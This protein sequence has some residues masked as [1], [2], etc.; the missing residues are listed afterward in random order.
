MDFRENLATKIGLDES[1]LPFVGEMLEV[2]EEESVWQGAIER[3]LKGFALSLLIEDKHY[4]ALS[5]FLNSTH[6][7]R[8]VV[9]YRTSDVHDS[10]RKSLGPSSLINKLRVKDSKFKTWLMAELN[11]RFDFTCAEAMR[12]FQSHDYSITKE[13]LVKRG[14]ARHEKDDQSHIGDQRRRVLGFNNQSKLKLFMVQAQQLASDIAQL[15]S[16]TDELNSRV[17]EGGRRA[18]LCQG[19][20]N[21]QWNEVDV[22]AIV[23]E[24]AALD[25]NI[26]AAKSSNTG[27]Q[28]I[29]KRVTEETFKL[30][31]VDNQYRDLK[32]KLEKHREQQGILIRRK[33]KLQEECS[34]Y[35]LSLE[36]RKELE[37]RI[38]VDSTILTLENMAELVRQLEKKLSQEIELSV[39]DKGKLEREIEKRFVEFKRNWAPEAAD[40]DTNLMSAQEYF[41]K[42]TRLET[43]N[44]PAYEER[45]F[46]L[47]RTQS[48]Q[49]LAALSSHLQ[50][51]RKEITDKL[52]L[53]NQG[54]SQAPFNPGTFLTIISTERQLPEVREFKQAIQHVLGH[55]W[56]E[57]REMA[58]ARFQV[59]RGLVTRLN[60]QEPQDRRWRDLVLDVRQHVEF[61]A[62]EA[63]E[64]G[65]EVEIYR[66]GSGKSG[67]Q[68]QKLATTCLAAA[69][70]YQLGGFD[71]GSP[72]YAPVI[73]DEAFD[74][75]DPDFTTLAMNIFKN[76]G[77]QMIVATPLKSVMTLEPF[78]GGA[79]VVGIRDRK[80]SGI[81]LVEYDSKD[82]RLKLPEASITD[83]VEV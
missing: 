52:E 81:I 34:K 19:I 60:G 16:I 47:L 46:E 27:L 17:R 37:N 75:A 44:L 72:S 41:V 69:L 74:K 8:K 7:G 12:E 48:H 65:T 21:L 20:V 3:V 59:L 5:G 11:Q 22:P 83:E 10:N 43:D 73:L 6:L 33:E 76:F 14:K 45:F 32:F 38:I 50:Q 25:Q 13:G 66:S 78:I 4:S 54:L 77:F 82:S 68:R 57:D 58:E 80:H 9:Y 67:G 70:R 18:M 23:K 31:E 49:N 55:A 51:S 71:S 39:K 35:Q 36:I 28:Q 42:L 29:E 1:S 63:H 15:Q 61:M 64:D 40:M 56:T 79:C 24:I 53:V 62:R 26:K 30:N 2:K